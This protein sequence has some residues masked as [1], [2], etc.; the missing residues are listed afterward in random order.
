MNPST[1]E[2]R[3]PRFEPG[4]FSREQYEQAGVAM[5]CRSFSEYAAMFELD[6]QAF[7]GLVV[8]DAAAGASS[9]CAGARAAGADAYGYDPRFGE[10]LGSWA[11]S[12]QEEIELSTAKLHALKD[13]FDWSYYGSLERHRAERVASLQSCLA[14]RASAEGE[15]RYVQAALPV[16]PAPDGRFDLVLCSHFLFLYAEQFGYGFHRDAILELMR[17]CRPGGR[18]LIYPLLSLRS[19][20]YPELDRLLDEIRAAGGRPSLRSSKLPFLPRSTQFLDIAR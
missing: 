8:A 16:L 4:S 3:V 10:P 14:D 19:E 13:K 18:V 1:G 9:F 2:G 20:P 6:P 7:R 5:T 11:L 12:A 15:G 17:V